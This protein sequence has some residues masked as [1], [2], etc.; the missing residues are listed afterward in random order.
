MRAVAAVLILAGLGVG[1]EAHAANGSAPDWEIDLDARLVT[2]NAAA[3]ANDGG[4]GT[5]RF[6]DDQQGLRLGRIRLA[7]N[8]SLGDLWS[9]H[10]D[11]SV[12]G[13]H[14]KNP[15]DLTE[16]YLQWRPYP[17]DGLRARVKA[18]AFYAPI[19]LENRTSGWETPYTITPSAINTWV[20]EELRTIGVE[21]QVDWLGT[22][23]GH[24]FDVGL[25]AAV[26]GWNDPAGTELAY[27]GFS[28]NDRQTTLFGR[29]GQPGQQP[30]PAATLFREIDGRPGA[31]AGV[32]VRY[33]D[34]VVL[35]ALHYDNRSDP[36]ESQLAPKSFSWLTR[37][38][39]AGIRAESASGWTGIAQWLKGDTYITPVNTRFGWPF[40]AKFLLVSRTAGRHTVSIRYDRFDVWRDAGQGDDGTQHGHAWTAAYIF[41]PTARWRFTLEWI[42]VTSTA[43][44]R[45]DYY[46]LDALAHEHQLQVQF[47]YA[48]GPAAAP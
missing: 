42:D 36:H 5:L 6:S 37:F 46:G 15:I 35:R 8:Q 40:E 27:W 22:R 26:Y 41:E 16:A 39:S 23:T 9:A 30:Q 18:G 11:A 45:N 33:L 1:A 44:S 13:D 12:W 4:P 38:D 48:L 31:Y 3:G 14:E 25:T 17:F 32:E 47:R 21:A 28:F 19:S 29:V 2:S 24:L 43:E 20:G 10:V 34:R 7:L